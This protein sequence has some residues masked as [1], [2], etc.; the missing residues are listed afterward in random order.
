MSMQI[1]IVAPARR[2]KPSYSGTTSLPARHV[3]CR[4]AQKMP[5]A[6]RHA[7]FTAESFEC[8]PANNLYLSRCVS[9][10]ALKSSPLS[11]CE[12]ASIWLAT[13]LSS[14]VP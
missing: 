4:Q 3:E 9:S 8:S 1:G 7:W 2:M 6:R 10:Q 12:R 14:V 11:V 13:A 5:Q